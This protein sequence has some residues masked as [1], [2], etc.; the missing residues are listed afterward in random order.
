MCSCY[1]EELQPQEIVQKWFISHNS[2]FP[3]LEPYTKQS[4]EEVCVSE[5]ISNLLCPFQDIQLK[6]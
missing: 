4:S 2:K 1:N 6:C 5:V 3:S